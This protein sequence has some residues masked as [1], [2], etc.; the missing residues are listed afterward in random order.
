MSYETISD[1]INMCVVNEIGSDYIM[2]LTN[3]YSRNTYAVQISKDLLDKAMEQRAVWNEEPFK[4]SD[5]QKK[6]P[7]SMST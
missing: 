6:E 5:L 1:F 7:E 4:I 3:T 2:V